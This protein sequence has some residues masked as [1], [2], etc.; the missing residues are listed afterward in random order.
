[1]DERMN[2]V[3]RESLKQRTGFA[4][5]LQEYVEVLV[6]DIRDRV[7]DREVLLALSGG[8]DSSVCGAL[9]HRAIGDQLV[10]IF[11]DHGLMRK[12]ESEAVQALFDDQMHMRLIAV[13]ASERFFDKLEGV[14]DPE[15]KRKI[16]GEEFIRVF[17]EEAGKLGQIPFLAQGTIYP[18]ILESKSDKGGVKSHHNVGGLPEDFDFELVEPLRYL[19]KDEVREVGEALGLPDELIYRQPFPGPGL[20]VRIIGA[21][22][23]DKVRIVREADAILHEEVKRAGLD[24]DIWQ[25]LAACPGFRSV[26][27]KD[28]MRTYGQAIA[29]RA[30]TSRD[31]LTADVYPMPH[32]VLQR[33]SSRITTEVPGVNRVVYDVTPKPPGTIEWE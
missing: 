12:G 5:T 13:D 32:E 8:V 9:V 19:F 22:T 20:G 10:S 25:Y 28:G 11:V 1:M 26:G 30:V 16:I 29:I 15:S 6:Q 27:V 24:R 3:G 7:G 33:I 31:A 14:E 18:D 4:G 21:I 17:E 2:N 23:K